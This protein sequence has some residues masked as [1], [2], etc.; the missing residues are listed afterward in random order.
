MKS[1]EKYT[2]KS[3]AVGDGKIS[4][5]TGKN[6][7][8][9]QFVG[10]PHTP[11]ALADI[12]RFYKY[13]ELQ[14]IAKFLAVS[15]RGDTNTLFER[16]VSRWKELGDLVPEDVIPPPESY[17]RVNDWIA[18]FKEHFVQYDTGGNAHFHIP[19]KYK[20]VIR[21]RDRLNAKRN[22]GK[23]T[24]EEIKALEDIGFVFKGTLDD[25]WEV[26]L[27]M[28]REFKEKYGHLNVTPKDAASWPGLYVLARSFREDWKARQ[29]G[30]KCRRHNNERFAE[31]EAMGFNFNPKNV[32][33]DDPISSEVVDEPSPPSVSLGGTNNVV[34]PPSNTDRASSSTSVVAVSKSSP[35]PPPSSPFASKKEVYSLAAFQQQAR[36]EDRQLLHQQRREDQDRLER[37]RREDQE[38][39]ENGEKHQLSMMTMLNRHDDQLQDHGRQ[40][41]LNTSDQA[42]T[43]Q[44]LTR[45]NQRLGETRQNLGVMFDQISEHSVAIGRTPELIKREVKRLLARERVK[46]NKSIG[47]PSSGASLGSPSSTST[48]TYSDSDSDSPS[49]LPSFIS[50]STSP[51]VSSADGGSVID[52]AAMSP[53]PPSSPSPVPSSS[54]IVPLASIAYRTAPGS[55]AGDGRCGLRSVFQALL[56]LFGKEK[57]MAYLRQQGIELPPDYD[58]AWGGSK[59]LL[60]WIDELW[61]ECFSRYL[62]LVHTV[63]ARLAARRLP[64]GHSDRDFVEVNYITDM[65]D[66]ATDDFDRFSHV[67]EVFNDIG[68]IGNPSSDRLMDRR[69]GFVLGSLLNINIYAVVQ[70]ESDAQGRGVHT[71][72][73][74]GITIR[75]N[76]D[77]QHYDNQ[78]HLP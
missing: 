61:Q 57:F 71:E 48:S 59:E 78:G 13:K 41:A 63:E 9:Q 6:G 39:Q 2:L 22:A 43:R 73:T 56:Q 52:I 35:S 24:Q 21:G 70:G 18:Y 50:T 20:K 36:N 47:L 66:D 44:D 4:L 16:I 7:R 5:A 46:R 58:F 55:V 14:R 12:C 10:R 33:L 15:T 54:A 29:R 72:A 74:S 38:R 30:Q 37:Q 45:T 26:N 42:K 51:R 53:S 1:G 31:L 11:L 17:M 62:S 32:L 60:K 69:T 75:L 67:N 19:Q 25:K 40:I 64:V 27:S 3:S 34:I 23:L 8:N 68:S 76:Y 49:H 28:L 77:G 65:A